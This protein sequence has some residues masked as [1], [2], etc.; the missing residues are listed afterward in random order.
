LKGPPST[1]KRDMKS[2]IKIRRERAKEKEEGT[3]SEK[4]RAV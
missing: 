4:S 1:L 3:A 2:K